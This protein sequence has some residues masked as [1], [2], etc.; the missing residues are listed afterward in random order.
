MPL[1]RLAE[2]LGAEKRHDDAVAVLHRNAEAF[3]RFWNTWWELGR[4]YE[5]LA[6]RD[7]AI[8]AYKAVLERLPNHPGATAR[9]RALG[10]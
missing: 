1:V 6:R 5:A 4:N 2:R 8:A 3:P 9:L 7:D 10:G